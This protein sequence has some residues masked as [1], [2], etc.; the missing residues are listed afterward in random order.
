MTEKTKRPKFII[1]SGAKNGFYTL[2]M[3]TKVYSALVGGMVSGYRYIKTLST[4]KEKAI[5]KARDFIGDSNY[6][7]EITFDLTEWGT[8][9]KEES[10][11]WINYADHNSHV[12]EYYINKEFIN[13][14]DLPL[15]DKRQTFTGKILNYYTKSTAFGYQTKIW[16]LDDR[17][18]VLNLSLPSKIANLDRIELKGFKFSFDAVLNEDNYVIENYNLRHEHCNQLIKCAFV[19]R[20]TKIITDNQVDN[21]TNQE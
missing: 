12:E 21:Y 8:Y 15:S 17:G 3:E 4:D 20:P 2:A 13:V 14:I 6:N 7:F 16:F 9:W 10:N 1:S 11:E 19:K 5:E 18:F